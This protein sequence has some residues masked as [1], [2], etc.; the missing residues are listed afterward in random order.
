MD[1]RTL[2]REKDYIVFDG[3]TG[4]MLQKMGLEAGKSPE[5][6]NFEHPEWLAAIAKMYVDAGADMVCANTFGANAKKLSR[7]GLRVDE[8][9][10]AA[11]K[12][13]RAGA[14]DRALVA[15]D[16]GPIGQLL[17]P[18]G[19]L[20]FDE[21]YEL[22]K[23]QVIAGVKAGADL[24]SIETMS[25]LY[26]MKAALL[27][28]RE[29]SDLPVICSMS[30]AADGRTF[31]GCTPSAMALTLEGLGADVLG[32]NCSTGPDELMPI[33]KEL[34]EW[35]NLPIMFKPNAGMPDPLTNTY[36]M[37]P[38]MFA[39]EMVC[40]AE[41]GV[42]IFGGC[43][44]TTPEHIKVMSD[45][46]E[47]INF[48]NI[49]DENKDI[50]AAV[51]SASATVIID[52]PR[53]IG[54]RINPTGKPRLKEALRAGDMGYISRQAIEQ[55]DAGAE[56]L[57][58]NVGLPDI[59]EPSVMKRAVKVL[60][61]VV[62]APLQID[63]SDPKAIEDALRAYCGKAIV[64]S[65]NGDD[66][67]LDAILPIVK[68]YGASVVGLTLDKNGIPDSAEKRVKI[69][70]KIL[71]RA[72]YYGIR[73]E[74]VYIDCLTLTASAEQKAANETLNALR[75]VKDDLGL[76]T[77][78]GVSNI[79]FGLP[80]RELVSSTFLAMALYAGLD[81][82]IM[83]PNSDA[84][85]GALRAY[86][87]LKNIDISSREYIA[88]Y[89]SEEKSDAAP[90]KKETAKKPSEASSA[91]EL[92]LKKAIKK[93]LADCAVEETKKLL[94]SCS[95]MEIVNEHIVP[96]LDEIGADFEAGRIFLPQL[97]SAADAAGAG[98][99]VLRKKMSENKENAISQGKIIVATVK[100]DIHDI[101]KN[102][103]KTLLENYGYT[104]IDLG[105]DVPEKLVAETAKREN[106]KLVGLSALMT[107]T[108]PAMERTIKYIK[109]M[110]PDCMVMVGGAVL[111][112]DFAEKIGADYYSKN[113]NM[114]VEIAK[115]V[116]S[117]GSG[118]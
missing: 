77:V 8:T 2:L 51:C 31:T 17:E 100:G 101:G 41:F 3:A 69:A 78:L 57:D 38:D 105:K 67:S 80:K 75:A 92:T 118:N 71:D 83:N 114:G 70:K 103:A 13:A 43:C 54:E 4:T 113:A 107:T 76:K 15:L 16:I 24:V 34:S 111:T 58:V 116:F 48:T 20:S 91:G 73:R 53:V 86:R 55:I 37:T 112:E 90:G 109:E 81:L 14:G 96:A 47:K 61:G 27:A 65:V 45:A 49:K 28:V 22:Y 44:G 117:Q 110:C 60:Q 93:G 50:P 42:K 98:F 30:F 94:E 99:E 5:L 23:E 64:N 52:S 74:D 59:D 21:A 12:A 9:I 33:L 26:E 72:I 25:D 46:L 89:G 6:L 35:T 7:L 82:P 87:V 85:M 39:K 84:M 115:R 10:D 29:N 68:K 102:I 97:I 62:S 40:A 108:L 32:L 104:V 1:F 19:T 36:P 66:E 95:C 88:A 11:F 106:V 79:S 63:S 18:I 56:I